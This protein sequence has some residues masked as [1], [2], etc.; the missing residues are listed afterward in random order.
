LERRDL[1][2][3]WI[4]GP[5]KKHF[6]LP[7]PKDKA[8]RIKELM[9]RLSA[10]AAVSH[11]IDEL[12]EKV[13]KD[14]DLPEPGGIHP[15]G[16]ENEEVPPDGDRTTQPDGRNPQGLASLGQLVVVFVMAVVAMLLYFVGVPS[17]VPVI[18][19]LVMIALVPAVGVYMLAGN[20]STLRGARYGI[21]VRLGGPA[22]IFG[23]VFY[24]GLRYVTSSQPVNPPT[25]GI[26]FHLPDSKNNIAARDGKIILQ[27]DEPKSV[28]ITYGYASVARIPVGYGGKPVNFTLA[29]PGYELVN[30]NMTI[31]LSANELIYVPVK[32]TEEAGPHTGDTFKCGFYFHERG[33]QNALVRVDGK[34]TLQLDE[35]KSVPISQGYASAA[36]LQG[37]WE[38]SDVSY[39]VE[40]PGYRV[41]EKNAKAPLKRDGRI[42]IS[43][44][45]EE[46]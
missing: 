24:S 37:F 46:K 22:A 27:F 15:N 3:L 44:L 43:V 39:G 17:G 13:R 35:P 26:Y 4:K 12:W 18:F 20:S 28:P 10:L 32:R 16:S 42:Y 36:N 40:L 23:I 11:S 25:R 14:P 31:E 38:G 34:L 7:L 41:A 8:E 2:C 5:N 29:L 6:T 21:A 33:D 45:P 9:S 19:A 30:K 1:P